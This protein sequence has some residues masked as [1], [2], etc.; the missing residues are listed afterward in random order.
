MLFSQYGTGSAL[1]VL[2]LAAAHRPAEDAPPLRIQDLSHGCSGGSGGCRAPNSDL[3]PRSPSFFRSSYIGLESSARNL[4]ISDGGS[5]FE[6][7]SVIMPRVTCRSADRSWQANSTFSGDNSP[8]S[9]HSPNESQADKDLLVHSPTTTSSPGN[10]EPQ[11]PSRGKIPSGKAGASSTGTLG[12]FPRGRPK[13]KF[14]KATQPMRDPVLSHCSNMAT[15]ATLA[16]STEQQD[17]MGRRRLLNTQ[18]SPPWSPTDDV[19]LRELKDVR[20]LGWRE[21]ATYFPG[22]TSFGCQFRWRRLAAGLTRDNSSNRAALR[23]SLPQLNTALRSPP[24]DH[25]HH[26]NNNNSNSPPESAAT[27]ESQYSSSS[28]RLSTDSEYASL[29]SSSSSVGW[30]EPTRAGLERRS[31]F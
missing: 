10:H 4:H 17:N 15:I 6:K 31:T 3:Y 1:D 25:H 29:A 27:T 12:G 7:E 16:A 26:H 30:A 5:Y 20:H 18:N 14:R 21:I 24:Y 28:R 23:S 2:A 13:K 19:L 8:T 9:P 22:R 11:S